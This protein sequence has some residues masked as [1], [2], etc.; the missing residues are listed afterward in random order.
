MVGGDG[1]DTHAFGRG[2][3]NDAVQ[4]STVD[5][6]DRIVFDTD[7][8]HDQLWFQRS[9]DDLV[10]SV[11]GQG[12]MVTV[13]A[14]YEATAN[15]VGQIVAGDAYAATNAGIEAMVPAMASFTPPA[16]GQTTLPSEL[17]ANL[18]STLVANLAMRLSRTCRAG[19]ASTSVIKG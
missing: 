17:A 10:I 14:W 16:S 12:Q 1:N 6:T 5:G 19:C 3:G 7:V 15:R 4:A 2:D 8:A 13:G 11:I 18:S 9:G